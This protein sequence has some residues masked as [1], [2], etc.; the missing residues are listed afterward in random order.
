[1]GIDNPADLTALEAAVAALQVDVDAIELDVNAIREVTDSE[2]ILTEVAG[3]ITTDGTE[4]TVYT[5]ENPSG[6]FRPICAKVDFTNHT[7]GET[8]VLR[9]Y[10]R[11]A[12]GG[13]FVRQDATTFAGVPADLLIN[14]D[15]EPNRYGIRF[16]IEKTVGTN[17]AYDWDV[18]YEEA[19]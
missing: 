15:F 13:A 19:P 14:T 3:Q 11:I 1:M 16:T 10:Y 2:A 18:F 12:L 7:A 6:I 8:V 17:R 5:E 9:V 4:Q